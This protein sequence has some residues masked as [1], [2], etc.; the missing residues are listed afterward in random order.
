MITYRLDGLYSDPVLSVKL[1][2]S[3]VQLSLDTEDESFFS[4]E[5]SYVAYLSYLYYGRN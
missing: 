1:T 3:D 5:T 4:A 2:A